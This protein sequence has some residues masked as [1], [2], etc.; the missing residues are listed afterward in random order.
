MKNKSSMNQELQHYLAAGHGRGYEIVK[1]APEKYRKY[2]MDLCLRDS[3]FDLQS[4]GSRAV[5]AY[6]LSM[7]YHDYTPFMRKAIQKF[8]S[9]STVADW[10]AT[11]HLCDLLML[12]AFES[13][14]KSAAGAIW[15]Q[16]EKLYK[17][18]MTKRFSYFV[19]EVCQCYELIP[20]LQTRP[21]V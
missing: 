12:Y 4:E 16:Y 3:S 14:E 13:H 6:D 18:M 9:E 15:L 5:Y 2:V 7:L 8:M 19:N 1:A 11:Y 21:H 10:H 20:C 17:I